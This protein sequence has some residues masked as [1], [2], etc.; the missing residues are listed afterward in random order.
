MGCLL[1]PAAREECGT[2]SVGPE[3]QQWHQ[4]ICIL[5][6][7]TSRDKRDLLGKNLSVKAFI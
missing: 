5:G 1:G 6:E 7:G 4:E 3:Q 2:L